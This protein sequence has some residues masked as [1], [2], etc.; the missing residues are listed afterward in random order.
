MKA[1]LKELWRFRE[2]LFAMVERELR[3][4]YK[5]SALGFFWSLL[6]PLITVLVMTVVFKYVMNN[7]TPNFSAYIL[8]AYLPY[9]FFQLTLL[10]ASQS[11]LVALPVV[12]KVYF[13]REILPLASVFSNFIH[14][15]LAILVFFAYLLVVYLLDPRISPFS[16]TIL[17]LPALLL[18]NFALAAGLSLIVSALNTFYEDVKYIVSVLLYL[19]FFL[20]PIMYFSETVLYSGGLGGRNQLIYFL[21]HLNPVAM[22][23]TA[24]RKVL[25]PPQP[26]QVGENFYPALPLDWGLLGITAAMSLAALIGGYAMFNRMKWRFVERP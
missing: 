10:D 5:N 22:L 2:L 24:Y 16:W 26:V 7:D 21:Y 3:I 20:S 25:V 23:C 12:K 14:F 4:R 19:L 8:A 9:L 15:L 18:I 1:E 6:N 11:V 13:P 17:L